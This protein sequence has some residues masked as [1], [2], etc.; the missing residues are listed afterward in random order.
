MAT[1]PFLKRQY[2]D[3]G[4]TGRPTATTSRSPPSARSTAPSSA[5]PAPLDTSGGPYTSGA[6]VNNDIFGVTCE[7]IDTD[8][9]RV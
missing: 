6:D 5:S 2:I 9:V 1:G 7:L 3:T 8:T 4:W